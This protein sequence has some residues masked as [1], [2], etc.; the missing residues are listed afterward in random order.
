MESDAYDE[1]FDGI[2]DRK[3]NAG[4]HGLLDRPV[5]I[6][7]LWILRNDNPLKIIL[8]ENFD[9]LTIRHIYFDGNFD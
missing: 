9:G 1:Y 2:H 5:T 6:P 8:M 7:G 4:R 3:K